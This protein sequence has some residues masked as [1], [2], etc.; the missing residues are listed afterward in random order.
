MVLTDKALRDA[1]FRLVLVDPE[2]D[3]ISPLFRSAVVGIKAIQG[4]YPKRDHRHLLDTGGFDK[5]RLTV[6]MFVEVSTL[7][8]LC[9]WALG[10]GPGDH[11]SW[12][13]SSLI[14]IP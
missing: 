12:L 14:C 7:S 9:L 5:I 2:D 10:G 3:I 8:Y 4:L 1:C 6:K 11:A 13:S